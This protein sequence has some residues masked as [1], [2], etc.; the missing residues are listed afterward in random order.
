MH[1]RLPFVWIGG[2][3]GL[4][5]AV[6]LA[7]AATSHTVVDN[8]VDVLYRKTADGSLI[9]SVIRTADKHP[10]DVPPA[11]ATAKNKP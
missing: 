3:V 10:Y 5:A 6:Q 9:A 7:A 1:A 11:R 4:V 8:S 2:A